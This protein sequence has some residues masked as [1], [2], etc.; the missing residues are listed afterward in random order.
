MGERGGAQVTAA[1]RL[2]AHADALII[3]LRRTFGG[4]PD[5]V[6][7]VC[8]YL[9]DEP[10]H[11]ISMHHR[12]GGRV[13]Q[14]WSPPYVPGPRFGGRKPVYVLTSAQT[15]SG[16]EELAYDLQHLGRATVVG[17]RTRGGAHPRVGVRL[18][19]HLELTIP[20][21]RPVHP[22]SGGN[23]EGRGVEPDIPVPAAEA[24]DVAHRAAQEA[25]HDPGTH[26]VAA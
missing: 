21:A 15:F 19:P 13:R 3:D 14:S 22:V 5:M 7:L 8:G 18:H 16:G 12:D 25:V 2:L 24:L 20:V 26:A 4:D 17:E 23:W 1:M 9:F 10:T 11:L 6:A